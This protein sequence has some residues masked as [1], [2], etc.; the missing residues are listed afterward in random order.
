MF[1]ERHVSKQFN[2]FAREEP[3]ASVE[4][5]SA[6]KAKRRL[7]YGDEGG[8][9]KIRKR[10]YNKKKKEKP[11]EE[12]RYR[13]RMREKMR[14]VLAEN[15]RLRV[16]LKR[17]RRTLE[18]LKGEVRQLESNVGKFKDACSKLTPVAAELFLNE[19]NNFGKPATARY[20]NDKIKDFAIQMSFFSGSGYRHLRE[21]VFHLPSPRSLRNYLSKVQCQPGFL[22]SVINNM[23]EDITARSLTNKCTLILDETSCR[24]EVCWDPQLRSFSGRISKAFQDDNEEEA[25]TE[26]LADHVLVF[27]LVGLDGTWRDIIGFWFTNAC[28][29][30]KV[31]ELITEALNLTNKH[32]IDVKALVFD[33]LRSNVSMANQLGANLRLGPDFKCYFDHPANGDKVYIIMDACHMLKLMRNLFGDK[34]LIFIPGHQGPAN[35]YHLVT[36]V[37]NQESIGLRAG[38]KLTKRHIHYQNNKM[39][40]CLAA[41]LFS[42]SVATALESFME[43]R[44]DPRLINTATTA[45]FLRSI[46]KLFDFCNSRSKNTAGQRAPLTP[47]NY[48]EK[49]KEIMEIVEMLQGIRIKK[50]TTRGKYTQEC[51]ELVS[52]GIRK[53][54]II[55]FTATIT[56]IFEL[57]KELFMQEKPFK[58]LYTYLLLQD[59]IEQFFGQLRLHGGRN[60]N[61][62]TVQV[63]FIIRKMITIKCGRLALA[64][65]MNCNTIDVDVDVEVQED[66]DQGCIGV[67]MEYDN[68]S[69]CEEY[70][71]ALQSDTTLQTFKKRTLA[72]VSGYVIADIMKHLS[73]AVCCRALESSPNDELHA[74][75]AWLIRA[76]D[77]GEKLKIPSLSVFKVVMKSEEVFQYD[78]RRLKRLPQSPEI[79]QMLA[80]KV[81][82]NTAVE[83]LFPTLHQHSLEQNPALEEIHTVMLVKTIA[84]R[85]LKLRCLSYAKILSTSKVSVRNKSLKLVQFMGQ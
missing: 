66:D 65:N 32:G 20:Y 7:S 76:K 43:D 62:S 34:K 77:L 51:L 67:F 84:C 16:Q 38:N 10:G 54:A 53:T 27:M 47:E 80:I 74:D 52:E 19:I 48:N 21:K 70:A 42:R 12:V 59:Y 11:P 68:Y 40:V 71:A 1:Q 28:E 57:A 13:N 4:E 85:F 17:A 45:F 49:K 55:G 5:P 25:E 37:E 50:I 60:D 18:R 82:N 36:L 46:D 35:F 73:C 81:V 61:P 30:S 64:T 33:G 15:L 56:S 41:Q 83:K 23:K 39:K 29:S 2:D 79:I 69:D 22:I 3:S 78:I 24:R 75:L 63:K 9:H 6:P 8:P 44:S 58:Q 26:D 31:K 72:Y 14:N